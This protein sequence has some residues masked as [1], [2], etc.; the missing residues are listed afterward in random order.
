M[1]YVCIKREAQTCIVRVAFTPENQVKNKNYRV[2]AIIN[3]KEGLVQ[4]IQ[5][6]GCKAAL[7]MNKIIFT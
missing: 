7:G 3:E 2:T 4:D 1:G 5:C 6:S